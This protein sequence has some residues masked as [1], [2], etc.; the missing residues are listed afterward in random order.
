[1]KII[2]IIILIAATFGFVNSVNAQFLD[3][4]KNRI[5][6]RTEEV[7]VDKAANKAAE[8]TAN[9][10]D[11][12]LN[13]NLEGLFNF[14]AGQIDLSQLPESYHFDYNYTLKMASIDGD[15]QMN[16]LFN[17]NE[18]Y[19]GLKTEISPDMIMVFDNTNN[20]VVIK[21]NEIVFAMEI[22]ADQEFS[23]EDFDY[24]T[25]YTFT[26]LT[27]REYLG[28]NCKGY[29]IENDEHRILVYFAPDINV[30]FESTG[31]EDM[32]NISKEMK[33]FMN[34]YENGLMMYMEMNDKLSGDNNNNSSV[35]IECLAFEESSTN[36]RLR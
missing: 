5:I 29:Q 17:K 21:S 16:Y 11:K 30:K 26:E 6:E 2:K 34:K 10:M 36:V 14:G 32:V 24:D 20:A 7:I 19:I 23:D 4:L 9:V 13:P 1:M 12:I 27:D 28:Y 18:P 22:N 35:S 31:S 15:I 33:A 25:D 3:R 8:Q